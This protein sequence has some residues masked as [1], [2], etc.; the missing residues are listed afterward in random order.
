MLHRDNQTLTTNPGRTDQTSKLG[1]SHSKPGTKLI[2]TLLSLMSSVGLIT[3]NIA[4]PAHDRWHGYSNSFTLARDVPLYPQDT[5]PHMLPC[6][7]VPPRHCKGGN[8]DDTI[9]TTQ[10]TILHHS[11]IIITPSINITRGMDS[12]V[13]PTDFSPLLSLAPRNE[14]C[15]IKGKAVAHAGLWLVR[16]MSHNSSSRTGP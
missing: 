13:T 16:L 11:W 1:I 6:P 3:K 14:P 12:P 5:I 9:R 2:I 7:E 4:Q 8:R 15:Y 10:P